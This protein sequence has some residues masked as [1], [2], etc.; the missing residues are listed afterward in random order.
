MGVW[1][2]ASVGVAVG[3]R[4]SRAGSVGPGS[5]VVGQE[6]RHHAGGVAQGFSWCQLVPWKLFR[7]KQSAYVSNPAASCDCPRDSQSCHGVPEAR[8]ALGAGVPMLPC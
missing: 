8:V 1:L 7:G 6:C 3:G 4:G 5:D 2:D